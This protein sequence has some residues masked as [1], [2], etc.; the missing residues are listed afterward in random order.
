MLFVIYV[1]VAILATY[2][3]EAPLREVIIRAVLAA[4]LIVTACAVTGMQ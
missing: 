3:K 2:K 4:T 1:I